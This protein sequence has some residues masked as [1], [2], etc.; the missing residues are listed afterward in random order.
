MYLTQ[1]NVFLHKC[2]VLM[3]ISSQISSLS[4]QRQKPTAGQDTNQNNQ[5]ILISS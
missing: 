4:K 3:E 5:N 1:Q 2:K